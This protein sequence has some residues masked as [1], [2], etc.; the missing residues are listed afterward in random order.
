MNQFENIKCILEK[1]NIKV[2]IKELKN[3]K[4]AKD[5][6]SQLN[7]KEFQL[8]KCITFKHGE[9]LVILVKSAATEPGIE[10]IKNKLG[11]VERAS[12]AFILEKTGLKTQ[13]IHPLH[14]SEDCIIVLDEKLEEGSGFWCSVDFYLSGVF[15]ITAKDFKRITNAKVVKFC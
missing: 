6:A 7:C 10:V 4:S 9:K 8:S 11:E 2:E 15:F 1:N 12:N 14:T 3:A 13:E 5:A